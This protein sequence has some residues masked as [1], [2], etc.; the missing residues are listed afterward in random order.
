VVLVNVK[1][2]EVQNLYLDFASNKTMIGHL[3]INSNPTGAQ[4]FLNDS[5]INH[6]TPYKL[7]GMVPGNY[8]LRLVRPQYWDEEG[9]VSVRSIVTTYIDYQLT[10]SITWVNMNTNRT[11]IP[12]DYLTA[13]AVEKGYIK[14]IGTLD[15]GLIVYDDREWKVYNM[16]NSILPDNKIN[17][18]H[19]DR[20]NVK[21]ICTDFGVV[22]INGEEWTL[23]N[24]SNSGLPDN[25]IS[26]A[27]HDDTKIWLGTYSKGVAVYD[28]ISWSELNTQNW[29]LPSNRVTCISQNW[30]SMWVG[31]D[32]GLLKV[33]NDTIVRVLTSKNTIRKYSSASCGFP[34]D[35]IN[36]IAL[37]LEG[38]AWVGC[39]VDFQG[40][41][42][43]LGYERYAY[44]RCFIGRP[45]E[46]VYSIKVDV[47][48]VKWIG[49]SANG[50]SRCVNNQ[51]TEQ[52]THYNIA[53][54]AIGSDRIYSI[55][56]DGNGHKWLA[57]FGGGLIKY[58]GN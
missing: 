38:K 50:L 46:E 4:I 26:S 58:K 37:D 27:Y 19:I 10:D 32:N 35:K 44:F 30:N 13:V 52:W 43:G 24:T 12:T 34:T 55:A 53:N 39:G 2:G 57:T 8:K 49:S 11:G 5:S 56:I 54:S 1:E 21:W 23:Y 29:Y 22:K 31:T 9:T 25:R 51:Y 16:S 17:Y 41:P 18:I 47:N 6:V 48:N 15:E 7:T 40:A 3:Y 28:G 20:S 36:V 45:S 33:T 42:G 14:W